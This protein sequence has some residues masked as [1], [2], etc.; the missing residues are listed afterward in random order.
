MTLWTKKPIFWIA[1]LGLAGLCSI[2]PAVLGIWSISREDAKLK[3]L[4]LIGVAIEHDDAETVRKW[5]ATGADVNQHMGS[6]RYT[7]LGYAAAFG[8]VEIARILIDAGA[9]MSDDLPLYDAAYRGEVAAADLLISKGMEVNGGKAYPPLMAAAQNGKV[10]MIEFLISR[11]ANVERQGYDGN[12]PLHEAAH[13]GH[14]EAVKVLLAHGADVN[15]RNGLGLTPLHDAARNGFLEIVKLLLSYG[16]DVNAKDSGGETPL[17]SA[18]SEGH[19]D[20]VAFLLDNG[21]SGP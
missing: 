4:R 20:V 14:L 6:G 18:R 9:D 19:P 15:C 11:G 10:E 13:S 5:V 16:A 8:H 7:P 1:V 3:Q 12:R 21:A 2:A 17:Q